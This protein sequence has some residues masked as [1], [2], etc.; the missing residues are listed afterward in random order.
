MVV[1]SD[2]EDFRNGFLH[3]WEMVEEWEA[4]NGRPI[5]VIIAP[6]TGHSRPIREGYLLMLKDKLDTLPDGASVKMVWSIHGMPWR[7][8]PNES[9]LKMAPAYRDVLVEDTEN[10][11]RNNT[12]EILTGA[13]EELFRQY[14]FSR[15]EVV[16]SQDHFADKYW[17]PEKKSLSTNRAYREGIRD[18]FDHVLNLPIEF[19]TENTDT[20][21]YHAMVNYEG[22]PGYSPTDKIDYPD[23]DKPYTRHFEIDGTQIDYLGV[24]TGDRYRPYVAK[25]MF[26]AWDSVLSRGDTTVLSRAGDPTL[27]R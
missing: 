9:W 5:K 25:A 14:N 27:T 22:F 24:P 26:Q 16:V 13:T 19:Y 7:A 1:Y 8:F 18:G 20:L 21:F 2:Y 4:A 23:W 15:T 12:K 11:L 17:D 10:L 3:T 6:P